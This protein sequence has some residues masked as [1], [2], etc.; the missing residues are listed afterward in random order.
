MIE[1]LPV[2]GMPTTIARVAPLPASAPS[3]AATRL[4]DAVILAVDRDGGAAVRR[5][6]PAIPAS[7][8]GRQGLRGP[9]RRARGLRAGEPVERGVRAGS[10]HPRVEHLDEHV[11]DAQPLA[12]LAHRLRH[13]PGVPLDLRCGAR[14]CGAAHAA[15]RLRGGQMPTSALP[16]TSASRSDA[17]VA[18][19]VAL[20]AVVAEH[21]VARAAGRRPPARCGGRET[22]RTVRRSTRPSMVDDAVAHLDALAGQPDDALDVR[23]GVRRV[24]PEGDDVAAPDRR[25]SRYASVLISTISPA[26]TRGS[27][28][29][30][31]TGDVRMKNA[32]AMRASTTTCADSET[33]VRAFATDALLPAAPRHSRL[34]RASS[35]GCGCGSAART[36]GTRG[37]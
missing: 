31:S 23:L 12:E 6:T 37:R 21:V 20:G 22:A 36:A 7:R 2:F 17:P 18:R 27:I 5:T 16:T 8:A 24:V 33:T 29:S 26:C 34:S 25:R 3:A 1:D 19:V 15:S 9:A 32:V 28:D 30:P 4:T 13:V 10:R 14:R 11:D 35:A